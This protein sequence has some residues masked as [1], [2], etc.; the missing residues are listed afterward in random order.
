MERQRTL[1][2]VRGVSASVKRILCFVGIAAV[3]LIGIGQSP[4]AGQSSPQPSPF[5]ADSSV[6]PVQKVL[7]LFFTLPF[8][9]GEV[10]LAS[11]GVSNAELS[12]VGPLASPSTGSEN[13]LI[14]DNDLQDCPN[15]EFMTIQSAVAA[16]SPGAK[17]KVCRGVYVEQVVIPLGKDGLTL[18]S[19]G[20][21]Q[22]VIKAPPVMVDDKA[23]SQSE[24]HRT[25]H[26]GISP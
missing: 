19:E 4:T 7:D 12:T 13:M 17:I 21:F 2:K 6:Q 16:A 22:A 5:D 24:E 3:V 14:V 23:S 26:S 25:S 8:A 15:A 1:V 10:N 11:L 18:F 9:L 20:A